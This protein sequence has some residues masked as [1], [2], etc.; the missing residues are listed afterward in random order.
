MSAN[1]VGEMFI[2]EDR[3]DNARYIKILKDAIQ[4][5]Y[6][7]LFS[8]LDLKNIKFQQDNAPCHKSNA[9]MKQMAH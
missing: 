9:T 1:G 4:S 3:I 7:K 2:C 5:S 6:R 8:D